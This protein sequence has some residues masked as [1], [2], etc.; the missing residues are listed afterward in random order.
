[1]TNA[2]RDEN[3]IPVKLA[4]SNADGITTLPLTLDPSTH[5]LS[6]DDD[7]TGSPVTSAYADRDENHVP[8]MMAVSS[9][10]GVTPVPLVIDSATGKL[11]INSN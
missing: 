11:L 3:H 5:G 4:I 7:T 8:V 9:A 6:V 1:M 10:D 2:Y